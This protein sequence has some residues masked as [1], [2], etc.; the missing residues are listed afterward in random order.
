MRASW[1]SFARTL[2]TGTMLGLVILGAGGRIAMAMITADAG[3]TPSFSVGGTM[4]VVM[5]GAVSGFAGA[6]MAIVSRIIAERLLPRAEWIQYPLFGAMLLLV[7]MRG[8]RGTPPAGAG[9][10]FV[11]VALYGIALAW[12]TRRRPLARP[13]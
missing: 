11:L 3:G 2:V 6:A 5:L 12:V 4:T 9:Y 13:A 10:F 1:R 8:L 7:T